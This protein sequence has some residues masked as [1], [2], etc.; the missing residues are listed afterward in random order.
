MKQKN[1]IF[2]ILAYILLCFSPTTLFSQVEDST[3]IYQYF[4]VDE[5]PKFNYEDNNLS[6]YLWSKFY[7]PNN[8]GATGEVVVSYIVNANG[9]VENLK[10]VKSLG[11]ICDELVLS[12]FENIPKFEPGKIN[13]KTVKVRMFFPMKFILK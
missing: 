5:L 8:V 6:E 7:W 11:S 9:K 1:K 10:I 12:L 2:V 13:G 4:E 3:K